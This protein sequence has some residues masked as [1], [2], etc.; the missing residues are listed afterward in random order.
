MALIIPKKLIYLAHPRTASK[1][2]VIGLATSFARLEAE[3]IQ[4]HHLQLHNFLDRLQ[5]GEI[6][7]TTVRHHGDAL[8]SWYLNTGGE[9]EWGDFKTFLRD[10]DHPVLYGKENSRIY[11]LHLQYADRVLRFENLQ[12]DIERLISDIGL[13]PLKLTPM[14]STAGKEPWQN[15][16]D[17][18]AKELVTA[19]FGQE[20]EELSYAFDA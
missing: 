19:R 11:N 1:S 14:N 18:E 17:D 16:Y 20:M 4:P 6:V 5:G 8:V 3:V 7:A 2:T 9:K 15:Y 13:P 10:W 12:D